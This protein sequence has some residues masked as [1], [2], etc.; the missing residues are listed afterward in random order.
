MLNIFNTSI[1]H[2]PIGSRKGREGLMVVW[3]TL[4]LERIINC[5]NRISL[6]TT[7]NAIKVVFTS[8]TLWGGFLLLGS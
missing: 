5:L 3:S 7:M 6:L 1:V 8:L 2:Q 4:R